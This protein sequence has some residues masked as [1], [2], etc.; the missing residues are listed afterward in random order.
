MSKINVLVWL[1][2]TGVSEEESVPCLCPSFW[3]L[4]AILGTSCLIGLIF[5][6]LPQFPHSLLPY[7]FLCLNFPLL[8]RTAVKLDL[9]FNLTHYDF[10][11]T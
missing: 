2:P 3:L 4:L 9:E 10:I 11:F 1:V 7:S 6:S 8:I 5:H